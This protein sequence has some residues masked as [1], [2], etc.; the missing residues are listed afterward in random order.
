M[1]QKDI[2]KDKPGGENYDHI[3]QCLLFDADEHGLHTD[4]HEEG[5]MDKINEHN[6]FRWLLT[7]ASHIYKSIFVNSQ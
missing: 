7:H 3:T 2:L 6:N 1:G 4:R 5:L